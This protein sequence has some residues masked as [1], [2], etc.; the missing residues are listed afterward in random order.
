M[1]EEKHAWLKSFMVAVDMPIHLTYRGLDEFR[2]ALWA[3]TRPYSHRI[4]GPDRDNVL[5]IF[6]RF[7]VQGEMAV[8]HEMVDRVIGVFDHFVATGKGG[9]CT[10]K[11]T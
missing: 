9:R 2:S 4:D 5:H 8:P 6:F 1:T 7:S 10:A 3:A 11:E